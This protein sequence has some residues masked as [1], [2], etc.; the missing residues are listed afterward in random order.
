MAVTTYK[1]SPALH[2][3]VEQ[4]AERLKEAGMPKL[5][6]SAGVLLLA[7]LTLNVEAADLDTPDAKAALE[8]DNAGAGKRIGLRVGAALAGKMAADETLLFKR[9]G[10]RVS[11][12]AICRL[13]LVKFDPALAAHLAALHLKE[14]VRTI[15]PAR[16]EGFAVVAQNAPAETPVLFHRDRRVAE[17]IAAGNNARVHEACIFITPKEQG[18][19]VLP[20][21]QP[22]AVASEKAAAIEGVKELGGKL[23]M[24]PDKLVRLVAP[25]FGVRAT[26]DQQTRATI[27]PA[28]INAVVSHYGDGHRRDA[29]GHR[30]SL[31]STARECGCSVPTVRK[32]LGLESAKGTAS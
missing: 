23:G 16:Y 30:I 28:L 27:T 19:K 17:K 6:T 5:A 31:V 24:E 26:I 12:N 20:T 15:K 25:A 10:R 11:T 1:F 18:E 7:I 8:R 2:A 3:K 29:A 13:A 9:L 14:E 21:K 22:Y 32:I 4:A